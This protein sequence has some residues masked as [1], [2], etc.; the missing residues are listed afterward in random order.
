[1]D[2][3]LEQFLIEGPELL[4]QASDDLLALERG[5]ADAS[6]IASVFRAIHTLKG[7]A[8]L[9][10]FGPMT[11]VLHAAEDLLGAMRGRQVSADRQILDGLLDCIGVNERWV[12]AIASTGSLPA[13]ADSESR[14]LMALLSLSQEMAP[15][16]QEPADDGSSAWLPALLARSPEIVAEAASA[17]YSLTGFRYLPAEDSFLLGDD[18]LATLRAVPGLEV[19]HLEID[20]PESLPLD[21]FDPFACHLA[22]EGLSSAPIEAVR[23]AFRLAGDR[24]VFGDATAMPMSVAAEAAPVADTGGATLRVDV[25]RIDA[26]VDLVGELI[27][28]KNGL[29]HLV[30]EAN[31]QA[32]DLAK[33]LRANQADLDRLVGDMRRA[34]MS[35]RMLKFDRTFRRFPRLVRELAGQLGKEVHFSIE[36]GDTEA[37]KTIVDAVFEP[38]LHLLRNAVDHGIETPGSRRAANKPDAGRVLLRAE[39]GGGQVVI[40]ITDDGAGIDPMKVREIARARNL[41][42]PAA[43]DGL[44]DQ[45]LIDLIFSPGFSTATQVTNISGRGVGLDVVAATTRRLGGNVEA[46]SSP[47]CGS[48]MRLV[49]PQSF[50]LTTVIVVRVGDERYGIPLDVVVETVRVPRDRILA[51]HHGSAFVLRDK[52]IPLLQLSSLLDL[53]SRDRS[54]G[55][56]KILVIASGGQTIGIEVDGFAERIDVMLRPMAGLLSGLRGVLG[57]ALMG[58]GRVLMVLNLPEIAG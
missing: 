30:A 49:L 13:D 47:G 29:A 48:T 1:M 57:T 24:V 53:P 35:T 43:L 11:S 58:D 32:P 22:I 18:P 25:A 55:A 5:P 21:E 2:E 16:T 44:S 27:V 15:A 37:D 54:A 33:A 10:D 38:L 50:A 19:V 9:F 51:V 26:L 8:G 3:L 20:R 23:R 42:D 28:A 31:R 40:T 34:V 39:S 17:D 41:M 45:G 46:T 36:G 4:Q 7:S 6:R 56:A 14:R 52:T 12:E